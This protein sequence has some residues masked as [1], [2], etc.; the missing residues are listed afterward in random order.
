MDRFLYLGKV[1]E[2]EKADDRKYARF[3]VEL[4]GFEGKPVVRKVRWVSPAAT[5]DAGHVWLP[6]VGDEVVV[7]P[8]A[9]PEDWV[10]LGCLYNGT[11]TPPFSNDDGKN[12]ERLWITPGGSEVRLNDEEG[13]ESIT[14]ATK[15]GCELLIS[16]ESGSEM[17]SITSNKDVLIDAKS[18]GGVMIKSGGDTVVKATGNVEVKATG[19]LNLEGTTGAKLKSSVNLDVEATG[20]LTLKGVNVTLEG[21]AMV[22]VKG[23]MIKLGK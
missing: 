20:N 9:G 15:K 6:D 5:K 3:N 11:N 4:V 18:D 21:T 12:L 8:L 22:T 17:I 14:I 23:P 16:Q 19:E 1:V 2:A 13:K 10:A 7:A